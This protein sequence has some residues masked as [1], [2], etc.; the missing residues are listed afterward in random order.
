MEPTVEPAVAPKRTVIVDEANAQV[1]IYPDSHEERQNTIAGSSEAAER[2][3]SFS[4]S[5][6][7]FLAD[8]QTDFLRPL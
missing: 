4:D 3:F 5:Q 8:L 7:A 2:S 1:V 6:A